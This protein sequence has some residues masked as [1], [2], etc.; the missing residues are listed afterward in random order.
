MKNSALPLPL[1]NKMCW[2]AGEVI[3]KEQ[4]FFR[5]TFRNQYDQPVPWEGSG[6]RVLYENETMAIEKHYILD[7][8]NVEIQTHHLY[9]TGYVNIGKINESLILV[10]F[11]LQS[12]ADADDYKRQNFDHCLPRMF[13]HN[14]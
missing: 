3:E 5:I 10:N 14:S 12:L 1:S 11:E 8:S 13:F 7:F 4:M 9:L 6:A 2:L